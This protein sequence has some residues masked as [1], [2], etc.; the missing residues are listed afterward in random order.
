M[1]SFEEVYQLL[2][3]SF[4]HAHGESFAETKY[5]QFTNL[6][7]VMEFAR[8]RRGTGGFSSRTQAFRQTA[9][10]R[11]QIGWGQQLRHHRPPPL[12]IVRTNGNA[13]ESSM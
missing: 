3:V 9:I 4:D 1:D 10:H 2:E 6:W 11:S 7:K 8:R 12:P 5:K 13:K